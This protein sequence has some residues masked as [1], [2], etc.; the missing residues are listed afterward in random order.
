V[1]PP[2]LEPDTFKGSAWIA[3]TPFEVRNLCLR[4]TWPLPKISRFAEINVRTYV[5]LGGRPGIYFFSLDAAS[6]PAVAAAR[7][8]YRLPY[9]RARMRID[10]DA[11]EI[12]YRSE[13]V[14][15]EEV[16]AAAFAASYRPVAE[17]TPAPAGSLEHW[18]TERY[19]LYTLDE[20]QHVL[21]AEIHHPPWP[22]QPAEAE[23]VRNSMTDQIGVGLRG[24]P[25]LHYSARQD[26]IF[27]SPE[28]AS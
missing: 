20:R 1:M 16:P 28:R 4:A 17:P 8:F 7:H 5:S 14:R 9:H 26:V 21:R 24:S 2:Q 22:L 15:S 25:L 18:L 12:H 19:C 13:R 11:A 6:W 27:W 23:I 10:R 3:I